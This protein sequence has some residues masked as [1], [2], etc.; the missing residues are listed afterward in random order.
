V[1]TVKFAFDFLGQDYNPIHKA[2]QVEDGALGVLGALL[3]SCTP[4]LQ[5]ICRAICGK[6]SSN[7]DWK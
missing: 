4:L 6:Q 1:F 7:A 2:E 3:S 5:L